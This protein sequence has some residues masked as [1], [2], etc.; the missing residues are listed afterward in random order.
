MND[1]TSI[2]AGHEK[3]TS[4]FGDWPSFHDSEVLS[5]RLEREGYDEWTSPAVCATVH[6]FACRLN[7][8]SPTGVE[9]YNH[10]LVTFRFNLVVNLEL[11]GFN[12]QNAIFDLII[13]PSGHKTPEIPIDVTFQ[14][15]FGVGLSFSCQ[16]VEIVEVK[17]GLPTNSV[18]FDGV[19]P[20]STP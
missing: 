13:E 14:P 11:S 1:P 7:E 20:S 9:F 4:V 17:P 8:H 5:I 10:T 3:L 19:K 16:S 2:V 18:Y 15:S 6:V 12:Q